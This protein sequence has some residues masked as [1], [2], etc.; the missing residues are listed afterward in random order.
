MM[1]YLTPTWTFVVY[2]VVCAVGWWA[3]WWVYPET[4]GLGLEEVGLLLRDGWGVRG[5]KGREGMNDE[6]EREER[7]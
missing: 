6:E 7:G 5:R 1:E 2:A 4:N 3:I